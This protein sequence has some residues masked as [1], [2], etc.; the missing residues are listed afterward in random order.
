MDTV[1]GM[2][3]FVAVVEGGNFSAAGRALDL[4]A[5]SVSRHITTLED[6]LGVRLFHRT[7]RK[8]NVTEAGRLYYESAVRI[9]ADIERTHASV[10][11]LQT[12][13]RGLLRVNAPVGFG[14]L[15]IAPALP[16]FLRRYPDVR[17]DLTVTNRIV[18]LIEEGADLAIRVGHLTESTLITWTLAPS[19]HV[20]CGSPAYFKRHGRPRTPTDLTRHNCLLFRPRSGPHLWRFER[21]GVVEEVEVNGNIQANNSEAVHTVVAAGVGVGLLPMWIAGE[22]IQKGILQVLFADYQVS[23]IG[24]PTAIYAV[25]PPAKHV[26]PKVQVFVEFLTE[27]FKKLC[28][29]WED[30]LKPPES[31][32]V[33]LRAASPTALKQQREYQARS[34]Q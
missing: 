18:D 32:S 13:P 4:D 8:M 15:H 30:A 3:V 33:A 22:D 23:A 29:L 1:V 14:R 28:Q 20:V 19:V 9:L 24:N 11:Q 2:R 6:A 10:A 17:F 21:H 27:R 7:T 31:A 16:E 34:K 5:S 25:C 12:T 26:S